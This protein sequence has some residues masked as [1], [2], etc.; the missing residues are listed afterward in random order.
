[1]FTFSGPAMEMRYCRYLLTAAVPEGLKCFHAEAKP[2]TGAKWGKQLWIPLHTQ[3]IHAQTKT[4]ATV[5]GVQKALLENRKTTFGATH[6]SPNKGWS[7]PNVHSVVAGNLHF[8][9]SYRA[10]GDGRR[11]ERRGSRKSW[12]NVSHK[13]NHAT[14]QW[15][16]WFCA[17]RFFVVNEHGPRHRPYQWHGRKKKANQQTRWLGKHKQRSNSIIVTGVWR[18]L[19]SHLFK[20]HNWGA[21]LP[22]L[23]CFIIVTP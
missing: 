8:L 2:I 7:V 18:A 23:R 9:V 13:S 3:V 19:L 20:R 5:I 14:A 17:F 1:M 4:P 21:R 10:I 22:Q 16:F 11:R 6:I 15:G 12:C